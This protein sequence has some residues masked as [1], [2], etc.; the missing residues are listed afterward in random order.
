VVFVIEGMA[1][2][3]TTSAII[4]TPPPLLAPGGIWRRNNSR[5]VEGDIRRGKTSG[6]AR[7][8][9]GIVFVERHEHADPPHAVARLRARRERPRRCYSAC[10]IDPL[11]RGIGVQN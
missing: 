4:I 6:E 1:T 11:S 3:T 5:N 8:P 7:L 10:K 9:N 2:P